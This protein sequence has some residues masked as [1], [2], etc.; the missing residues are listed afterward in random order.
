MHLLNH[1][2]SLQLSAYVS[3]EEHTHDNIGRASHGI[4]A[5]T[6]ESINRLQALKLSTKAILNALTN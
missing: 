2:D 6:K 5:I 1:D 4:N 3:Q